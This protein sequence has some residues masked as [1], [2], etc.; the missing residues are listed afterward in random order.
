MI[1]QGFSSWC[2]P[3]VEHITHILGVDLMLPHGF[4]EFT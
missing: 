4:E 3:V 2:I 1:L